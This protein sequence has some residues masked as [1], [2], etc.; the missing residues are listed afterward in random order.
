MKKIILVLSL[1]LALSFLSSCQQDNK[2]NTDSGKNKVASTSTDTDNPRYIARELMTPWQIEKVYSEYG[3]NT[4]D[5]L[6]PISVTQAESYIAQKNM[7]F[8][9]DYY[10]THWGLTLQKDENSEDK[11]LLD[12][13]HEHISEWM[14][15]RENMKLMYTEIS[16][17][18]YYSI[19][20]LSGY[21]TSPHGLCL[22]Q[23]TL[24]D[25]KVNIINAEV[26]QQDLTMHGSYIGITNGSKP[27]CFGLIKQTQLS[28]DAS[29]RVES[30]ISYFEIK[31]ESNETYRIDIPEKPYFFIQAMRENESISDLIFYSS[32][33]KSLET[34]AADSGHIYTQSYNQE[35]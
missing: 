23:Y 32:D 21:D 16:P 15:M 2:E 24:S 5:D 25:G 31:T 35:D 29:K 14:L 34:M 11:L 19:V 1:L 9:S 12:T 17:D 27:I 6:L 10:E 3:K 18:G 4:Y 7:M 22:V 20:N 28:P 8:E 30:Q 26:A 13:L 33:G